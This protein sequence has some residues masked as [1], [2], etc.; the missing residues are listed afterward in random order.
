MYNLHKHIIYA[1]SMIRKYNVFLSNANKFFS[2]QAIT[3]HRKRDIKLILPCKF[4]QIQI[5]SILI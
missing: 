5:Q 4:K 2:F 3:S 1:K